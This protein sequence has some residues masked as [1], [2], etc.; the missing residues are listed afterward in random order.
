[1]ARTESTEARCCSCRTFT[2]HRVINTGILVPMAS[3][4]QNPTAGFPPGVEPRDTRPRFSKDAAGLAI[5]G[6]L[7]GGGLTRSAGGAVAGGTLG[8]AIAPSSPYPLDEALRILLKEKPIHF[9][10]VSR[11]GPFAAALVVQHDGGFFEF[12]SHAPSVDGWTQTALDDWL[13][14]D[15][16]KQV[17]A[18]LKVNLGL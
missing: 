17:L 11:R 7:I 18:W 3:T 16:K 5:L 14:G 1:M 6:A 10:K 13:Y 8:A 15:L 4:N 12:E 2:L 9:V